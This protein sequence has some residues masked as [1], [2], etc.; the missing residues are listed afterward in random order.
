MRKQIGL[1]FLEVG[2]FKTNLEQT[3]ATNNVIFVIF[4]PLWNK[5]IHSLIVR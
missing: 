4:H 2:K 5:R 1:N 3:T